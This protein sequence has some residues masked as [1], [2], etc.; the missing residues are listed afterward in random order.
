MIGRL[1][2]TLVDK[3]P[4]FLVIDVQGVGYEVEAPMS[5]VFELGETGRQVTVYT[6]LVVRDDAH[7]LYAFASEQAR[8]LFR[9]LIRVNGVGPKL[10]LVLLSGMDA[11]EFWSVVRNN[12]TARLTRLPGI[13]K[14]TAERLLV[15]MRDRAD[16]APATLGAAP[17]ASAPIEEARAALASLGYKPAEVQ[18]YLDAVQQDGMDAEQLIREALRRAV[19]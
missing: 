6:H 16:A 2:G 8:Q 1:T 18:K 9:A 4:P 5:T 19:R 12:D 17:V 14:K 13:G 10:A 7:L 15:E 3:Q 11:A